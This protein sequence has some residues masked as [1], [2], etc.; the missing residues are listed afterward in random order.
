MQF[1]Y[2]RNNDALTEQKLWIFAVF[3]WR[4]AH[5]LTTDA[6][7][8]PLEY[9]LHK[10]QEWKGWAYNDQIR[11]AAVEFEPDSTNRCRPRVRSRRYEWWEA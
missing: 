10:K 1:L 2:K 3:F 6:Y 4:T 8:W 5:A 7:S 9:D 11:S